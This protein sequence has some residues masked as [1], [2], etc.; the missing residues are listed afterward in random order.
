MNMTIKEVT[1]WLYKADGIEPNYNKINQAFKYIKKKYQITNIDNYDIPTSGP[2][3]SDLVNILVAYVHPS[4]DRKKSKFN[5]SFHNENGRIRKGQIEEES[6][7]DENKVKEMEINQFEQD[8]YYYLKGYDYELEAF[9]IRT[10]PITTWERE[11]IPNL[12]KDISNTGINLLFQRANIR[13]TWMKK[14]KKSIKQINN[15]S[16]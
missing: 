9:K 6:T 13:I 12:C 4:A 7:E 10:L 16:L 2:I 11:N 1:E 3:Y 15:Q 8:C 14:D 5:E